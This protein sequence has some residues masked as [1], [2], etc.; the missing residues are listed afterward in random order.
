M[1]FCCVVESAPPLSSISFPSSDVL[2]IAFAVLEC[3]D[4]SFGDFKLLLQFCDLTLSDGLVGEHS[5]VARWSIRRVFSSG[6]APATLD[7][8]RTLITSPT[9]VSMP[10]RYSLDDVTTSPGNTHIQGYTSR[11]VTSDITRVNIE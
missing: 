1:S 10:A 5:F 3:G 2:R 11:E 7:D 6:S 9:H 8:V 4:F